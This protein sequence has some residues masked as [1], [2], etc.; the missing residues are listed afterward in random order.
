MDRVIKFRAKRLDDPSHPWVEGFL[1]PYTKNNK[2]EMWIMPK[3]TASSVYGWPIDVDT[4]CQFTGMYDKNGK[5]VWEGDIVQYRTT[6]D[7]FK[8]KPQYV[9]L[10][11]NYDEETARFQAG[12]IYY[13]NLYSSRLE[14]VGNV[15]D[16]S[17]LLEERNR[18]KMV[19]HEKKFFVE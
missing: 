4:V 16:N 11:I 13:R 19:N 8:K 17:D 1:M 7:R 10:V 15:F 6:D 2:P 14:V 3:V 5:E 12:N 18:Y 9:N